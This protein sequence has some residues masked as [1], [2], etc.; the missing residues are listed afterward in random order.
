[1]VR[2]SRIEKEE[3]GLWVGCMESVCW[4][5]KVGGEE[6]VDGRQL[7]DVPRSFYFIFSFHQ[8]LASLSQGK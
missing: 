2:D 5:G 8:L 6:A 3:V 1:V 4:W 7:A